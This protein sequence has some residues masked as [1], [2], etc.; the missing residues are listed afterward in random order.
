MAK[1]SK[2]GL[3]NT[4]F[5][6]QQ[7][8]PAIPIIVVCCLLATLS[9]VLFWIV[10]KAL[11]VP[12]RSSSGPTFAAALS[13]SSSA[14]DCAQCRI[15]EPF[16]ATARI[17]NNTARNGAF[18][19]L[20]LRMSDTAAVDDALQARVNPQGTALSFREASSRCRLVPECAAFTAPML[21]F[22]ARSRRFPA[23]AFTFVSDAQV[24]HAG[25]G[26]FAFAQDWQTM[27]AMKQAY[28]VPPVRLGNNYAYSYAASYYC[29]RSNVHVRD[30][31][32]S[33]RYNLAVNPGV[34]ISIDHARMIADALGDCA[35]FAYSS[36]DESLPERRV[37][38]L[39]DDNLA[40]GLLGGTNVSDIYFLKERI[41]SGASPLG[42]AATTNRF[43]ELQINR[44]VI[45][46]SDEQQHLLDALPSDRFVRTGPSQDD[47]FAAGFARDSHLQHSLAG[48]FGYLVAHSKPCSPYQ[49]PV[50]CML[51]ESQIERL[52]ASHGGLLESESNGSTLLPGSMYADKA[53]RIWLRDAQNCCPPGETC[54]ADTAPCPP[55]GFAFFRKVL[56]S[57]HD[58]SGANGGEY[59]AEAV[60][61]TASGTRRAFNPPSKHEIDQFRVHPDGTVTAAPGVD[62]E[63]LRGFTFQRYDPLAESVVVQRQETGE[64]VQ[65][66]LVA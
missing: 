50:N 66:D 60:A 1:I 3:L 13:E 2:R 42:D 58:R 6:A 33:E 57:M 25:T 59:L 24:R 30:T 49:P 62:S 17:Q 20:Q 8:T 22:S 45:D 51:V 54:S 31:A 5:L 34:P 44:Y 16:Q 9:V 32:V 38:F 10:Y 28:C 40:P 48:D 52:K 18:C 21:A 15:T 65:L 27:C 53:G 56:E 64:L 4:V 43:A 63:A 41:C 55:R 61:A 19:Y 36:A 35:G 29:V 47:K 14:W 12:K 46:S 23:T 39:Q 26:L 7:M 11:R 37:I